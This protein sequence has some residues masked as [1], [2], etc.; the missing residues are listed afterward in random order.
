MNIPISL[1]IPPASAFA[2]MANNSAFKRDP[3][4]C[5]GRARLA[6]W[7]DPCPYLVGL[8]RD[9][10]NP[11]TIERVSAWCAAGGFELHRDSQDNLIARPWF[12][13]GDG[14]HYAFNGDA[15][16]VTVVEVSKSGTRV[17]V[18]R[19]K[20]RYGL[21]II[22]PHGK[23]MVFTRRQDG[24]Y[25]SSKCATWTLDLGRASERNREL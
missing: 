4:A 15:Y 6:C 8:A 20:T 11:K 5:C 14:A 19:D 23:T 16:P 10:R 17:T 24:A 3:C 13:V 2:A 12:N 18:R 22:D 7:H 9:I 21:F 25:R 1:P